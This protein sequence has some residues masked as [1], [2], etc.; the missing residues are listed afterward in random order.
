MNIAKVISTT[1]YIS[2]NKELIK[3]LG[4][5]CATLLGDLASKYEYWKERDGLTE[6]G[7]FFVTAEYIEKEIGLSEYKQ[8]KAFNKLEQENLIE[9]KIYGLP[10]KKYFKLNDSKIAE[11][12]LANH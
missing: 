10:K 2:V 3:Q 12:I 5:E 9:T 1:G 7:F 8:R 4:L 6:D 11:I